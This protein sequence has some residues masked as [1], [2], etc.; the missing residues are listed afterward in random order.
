MFYTITSI[1]WREVG[2]APVDNRRRMLETSWSVHER[3]AL[4][5]IVAGRY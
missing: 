2:A 3:L 4:E 1:I 5:L